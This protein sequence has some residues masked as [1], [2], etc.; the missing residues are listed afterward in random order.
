MTTEEIIREYPELD[1]EDIQEAL[2]YAAALAN[3]Q[4]GFFKN[5]AA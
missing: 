5:P 1:A 4:I 2:Q 3:D